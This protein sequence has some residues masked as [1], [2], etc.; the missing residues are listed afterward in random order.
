LEDPD[1]ARDIVR[2]EGRRSVLLAQ[3][4]SLASRSAQLT[5]QGVNDPGSQIPV[6]RQA[7]ADVEQQLARRRQEQQQL[8]LS[9]PLDGEVIPPRQRR[10]TGANQVLDMWAGTPLDEQNRGA[11]LETGTLFCLVGDGGSLQAT[12]VVDQQQIEFVA[13]GQ[14]VR[15][16]LDQQLDRPLQ[17]VITE[18]AEVDADAVSPELVAVG[19]LPIRSLPNGETELAEVCYQATVELE[20]VPATLQP[21]GTGQA[22]IHARAQPLGRR[23][24][25]YLNNT[26]RL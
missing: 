2:L 17:G 3:L 6:T 26:F 25:R 11:L 13:S 14:T 18:I 23:L 5:H 9:A 22:K 1:L 19:A 20:Y 4:E 7:L 24:L 10:R 21:G 12:L 8:T 16:Q 15:L